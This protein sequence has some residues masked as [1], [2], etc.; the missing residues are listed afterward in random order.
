[1][2][3]L[4]FVCHISKKLTKWGKSKFVNIARGNIKK[5]YRSKTKLAYFARG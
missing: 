5:S 2:L 3:Q 1:M 4:T